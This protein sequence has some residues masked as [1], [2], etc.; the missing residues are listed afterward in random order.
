MTFIC[1]TQLNGGRYH[2]F[3]YCTRIIVPQFAILDERWFLNSKRR[4]KICSFWFAWVGSP[5]VLIIAFLGWRRLFMFFHLV[6]HGVG[7]LS[8][9]I[10]YF[11]FVPLFGWIVWMQ[12]FHLLLYSS[13][14]LYC[15]PS[16]EFATIVIWWF[17][18]L[19]FV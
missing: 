5:L 3:T 11:L 1:V 15:S 12:L 2:T 9:F 14:D 18:H 6:A 19:V 8:R 4:W 13:C 17:L 7:P 10:L 16:D